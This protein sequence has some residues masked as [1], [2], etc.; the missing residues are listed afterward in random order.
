M[1]ISAPAVASTGDIT[2]TGSTISSPSNADLTLTTSGSGD[3]VVSPDSFKVKLGSSD[4]MSVG[5]ASGTGQSVLQLQATAATAALKMYQTQGTVGSPATTTTGAALTEIISHAYHN[6]SNIEVA[7]ILTT[8]VS[9]NARD[10]KMELQTR[11]KDSDALVTALTISE[12]QV[13]TIPNLALTTPLSVANGGTGVDTFVADRI[14]TG[15]GTSNITQ[16][17]V[18]VDQNEITA[19][20]SNDDL[21]LS[22]SGTGSVK[23]DKV[24]INGGVITGITDLAVADGGTGASS[25]TDNAVLTGTGTSAIT[26]ESN[27][28]F[29]GSTLA[30]TGA[31]TISTQRS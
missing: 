9:S 8:N 10:A 4:T 22:G 3:V 31:A 18:S 6:G 23:I 27:L 29:N 25:L 30:V 2:F 26:A 16:P 11:N 20:R 13:V 21:V 15:D 24:D 5:P 7:R 17:F 19:S 12:A 1:T 28:S 14:L